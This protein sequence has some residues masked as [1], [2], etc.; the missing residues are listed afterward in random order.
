MV[1]SQRARWVR[2]WSCSR[3]WAREPSVAMKIVS[4][5]G[6][7]ADDLGPAS[8]VERRGDTLRRAGGRAQHGQARPGR[9]EM[10]DERAHVL[11]M[12]RRERVL[13]DGQQVAIRALDDAD[14]AQ[15]AADA[16]LRRLEPLAMQQAR[17]ARPGAP[18]HCRAGCERSLPAAATGGG[19]R[20]PRAASSCRAVNKE[21][22]NVHN[23]AQRVKLAAIA[24]SGSN[25]TSRI[26]ASV[27]DAMDE[28]RLLDL[29]RQPAWPGPDGPA[30]RRRRIRSRALR[31]NRTDRGRVAGG[32]RGRRRPTACAATGR[33]RRAT[34]RRRSKFA[35]R[36]SG[37]RDHACAAGS[38][39][40][41]MGSGRCP[42]GGSTSTIRRPARFGAR[43]SRRRASGAGGQARRALRPQCAWPHAVC[44]P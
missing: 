7:R 4:S 8:L 24:G 12:A 30:L 17:P 11:E 40:R 41:T 21:R 13:D 18:P 26:D 5:P 15:V 29:A 32:R 34:S 43:S 36:C 37:P 33:P 3:R 22:R 9:A 20:W 31:G 28:K 23:Y 6:D 38:G 16:R 44:L 42:A 35:A 10:L 1:G 27:P 39:N 14:F 19:G 25:P 2:R